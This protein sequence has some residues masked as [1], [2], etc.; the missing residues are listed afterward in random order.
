MLGTG[1]QARTHLRAIAAVR[2]IKHVKVFSPTPANRARYADEMSQLLQIEVVPCESPEEAV[3]G[4]DILASC[5]NANTPPV[6]ADMVA[7]GMHLDDVGGQFAPDVADKIDIIIG[8]GPK[9][10]LIG[11][12]PIDDS[13]GFPTEAP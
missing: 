1:W 12:I 2:D 4:V 10:Q 3:E 13:M 8:G 6:T 11:G 7:P 9:S 5:T